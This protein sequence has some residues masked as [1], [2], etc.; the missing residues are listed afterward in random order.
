MRKYLLCYIC[1]LLL[2]FIHA[3]PVAGLPVFESAASF[4]VNDSITSSSKPYALVAGGSKGI[5][6]GI[7]EA[8]ARRG[9]NL[10]LI[11]RHLDSLTA[12]KTKLEGMYH[13]QVEILANDL[14]RRESATEI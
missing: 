2:H 7:A 9:Y 10:V 12:A 13:I 11:A 4:P 8:L 5:G 14:S 3:Q 6:Y 1:V